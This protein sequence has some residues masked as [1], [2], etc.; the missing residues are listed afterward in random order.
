MFAA[1]IPELKPHRYSLTIVQLH[2]KIEEPNAK[3]LSPAPI[4]MSIHQNQLRLHTCNTNVTHKSHLNYPLVT[5]SIVS[6]KDAEK[7][8]VGVEREADSIAILLR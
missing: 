8:C 6:F 3:Q 4:S 7:I 5:A 1:C 2:T